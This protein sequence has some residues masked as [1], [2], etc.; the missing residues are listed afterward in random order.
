MQQLF[1]K[2]Q[3]RLSATALAAATTEQQQH[4]GN[5]SNNFR[6]WQQLNSLHW[7]KSF[8][9]WRAALIC[10]VAGLDRLPR[11]SGRGNGPCYYLVRRQFGTASA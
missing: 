10:M 11:P 3:E 9:F 7:Q 2:I 4:Y 1:G 6:D 8:G 5:S